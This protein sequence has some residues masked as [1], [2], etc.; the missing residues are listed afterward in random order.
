M[1]HAGDLGITSVVPTPRSLSN[2]IDARI[3]VGF[4]RPVDRATVNA[5]SF[6][7]FGRWSGAAVGEIEFS[8]GDSVVTLRPDRPFSAGEQV[9]VILSHDILAVDGSPLRMGGSSFQFWT[10]SRRAAFLYTPI[11]TMTTRTIPSVRTRSYGG[12]ATDLN[13]DGWLDLTIVNEDTADLRVFLNRADGTGLFHPFLVPT[14]PVNDRASP[15]EP[16]DFNFDGITDIAVANINTNNISILL[17][18]GDGTFGPQAV[19]AA[20][21]QPRGICVLDADGD[22]DTDVV[23]TNAG[24]G[25]LSLFLNDGA[26][27]FGAASFFDGGA[28]GEWALAAAD[29]TSDGML[30]LVIGAFQG[31]QLVVRRGLGN[32]TFGP[33]GS[34]S[35]SG[36]LWMLVTGDINGDGN[37]DACTVGSNT[38]LAHAALGDGAGNFLSHTSVATDPF[39][40]ADDLGD[41]DGD[42]D[43]DWLV[44]SFNGDW[45]AYTNNGSGVFSMLREFDAPQAASCALLL[46]FDN[47]RDLD[48][49]LI[50][51]LADVVILQENTSCPADWDRSGTVTSQDFFDFLGAFFGGGANFNLLGGT[52]SQDF[53]DFL[54]AFFTPCP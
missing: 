27:V 34:R 46:D 5:R 15:S 8:E 25:N 33:A 3:A 53:F 6:W 19:R 22:G 41:L 16:S 28:T 39:P 24:S 14:F 36:Q 32:G 12:I 30:D 54:A 38:N 1:C 52:D 21:S 13:R 11:A 35:V 4:D 18:N 31:Q 42:G 37:D 26:G 2:P 17:G 20:G 43:L 9:M 45:R 51:E 7:A 10:A 40:L 47:D 48:L 29:L 23:N 50:D 49:A 44:S